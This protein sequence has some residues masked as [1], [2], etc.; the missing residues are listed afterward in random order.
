LEQTQKCDGVK[1]IN[2]IPTLLFLITG[3]PTVVHI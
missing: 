1:P 3:S 2:R